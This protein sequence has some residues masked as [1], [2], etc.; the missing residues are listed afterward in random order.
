V[1]S[2]STVIGPVSSMDHWHLKM[3]P[4]G[5]LKAWE[6]TPKENEN[7]PQKQSSQVH[8]F[9]SLKTQASFKCLYI[10]TSY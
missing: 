2:S 3:R 6:I 1:V 9:K 10:C 8:H 4:L 7:I 5:S